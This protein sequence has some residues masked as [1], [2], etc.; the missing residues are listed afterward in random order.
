MAIHFLGRPEDAEDLQD[1]MRF[2]FGPERS[3]KE[4][5]HH[6]CY[7]VIADIA[8]PTALNTPG[9]LTRWGVKVAGHSMIAAD[10]YNGAAARYE[11]IET[12]CI[13]DLDIGHPECDGL[14]MRRF[15]MGVELKDRR[16]RKLFLKVDHKATDRSVVVAT[17][18]A[19]DRNEARQIMQ[20]LYLAFKSL[21]PKCGMYFIPGT[22]AKTKERY[23]Q[24][25][26]GLWQ[27]KSEMDYDSQARFHD[28]TLDER[29]LETL[30]HLTEAL[31]P[32][33]QTGNV[34]ENL[35][36]IFDEMGMT[37]ET[38]D[39]NSLR[40]SQKSAKTMTTLATRPNP[41]ANPTITTSQATEHTGNRPQ[42]TNDS[43]SDTSCLTMATMQ[44]KQQQDTDSEGSI[45]TM[46]T[47]QSSQKPTTPDEQNWDDRSNDSSI[48][49]LQTL[50]P[51]Q[52][53]APLNQ[54]A[55]AA[56]QASS[57]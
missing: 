17:F 20:M 57:Q 35:R 38:N 13:V 55:A 1:L 47:H 10:A 24:D 14:T 48:R 12:Q 41:T 4:V 42:N 29:G 6:V 5:P 49:S 39:Q 25:A 23:T 22:R 54:Q 53:Q 2:L 36:F 52:D 28:N 56:T 19:I 26:N 15:I 46:N 31:G 11:T 43:D 30:E 44:G 27:H 34:I 18:R 33:G 45:R 7:E 32:V 9:A 50:E 3:L 16:G 40:D 51:V 21:Y 8:E 37:N